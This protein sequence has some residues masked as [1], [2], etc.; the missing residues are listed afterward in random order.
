MNCSALGCTLK[1]WAAA[2]IAILS[3]G[4]FAFLL[5]MMLIAFTKQQNANISVNFGQN[6]QVPPPQS[7]N[8]NALRNP[9][10]ICLLMS[11]L[12]IIVFSLVKWRFTQEYLSVSLFPQFV[13]SGQ[14]L[15]A[16]HIIICVNITIFMIIYLN[17][18]KPN[19]NQGQRR[20]VCGL[21]VTSFMTFVIHGIMAFV[22]IFSCNINIMKPNSITA[23]VLRTAFSVSICA[24]IVY[25]YVSLKITSDLRNTKVVTNPPPNSRA[26]QIFP[27]QGSNFPFPS[28]YN[29]YPNQSNIGLFPSGQGLNPL[30]YDPYIQPNNN[31]PIPPPNTVYNP[32]PPPPPVGGFNTW[33]NPFPPPQNA[34]F[35]NIYN[36][37]TI[38][39]PIPPYDPYNP[40]LSPFPPPNPN[41]P[42]PQQPVTIELSVPV[43]ENQT[44]AK[45][46]PQL[47][48]P[49]FSDRPL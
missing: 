31:F 19:D 27:S 46:N 17:S 20:V 36:P 10:I 32:I 34:N 29:Q 47:P 48:T 23:N 45:V 37:N 42:A 49:Q 7:A 26:N 33:N 1:S 6:T 11:I 8:L 24:L 39:N 21:V 28:M 30:G 44:Q 16:G 25:T 13:Q 14:G 41:I 9:L 5:S 18:G 12:G 4:Y 15:L 2:I 43:P 35:N 3:V 40:G 38:Y 22:F